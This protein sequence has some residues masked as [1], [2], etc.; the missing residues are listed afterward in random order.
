MVDVCV[1]PERRLENVRRVGLRKG[2]GVRWTAEDAERKL[3]LKFFQKHRFIT[4]ILH[5]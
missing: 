1:M 3:N 2:G 4:H 5:F